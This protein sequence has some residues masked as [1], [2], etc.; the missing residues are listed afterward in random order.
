MDGLM[1]T[2]FWI[3]VWRFVIAEAILILRSYCIYLL[4]KYMWV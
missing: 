3:G 4:C 1:E 2:V